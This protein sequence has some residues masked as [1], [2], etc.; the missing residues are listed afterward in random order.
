MVAFDGTNFLIAWTD[1]FPTFGSDTNGIGNL[2]ARFVNPSGGTVGQAFTIATGINIKWGK[3]R[4]YLAFYDTTYFLTYQ[5]GVDHHSEYLYMLRLGRSG[6][7]VGSAVK[8]SE[9]YA[10]EGMFA[11]DG[12]NYLLVWCKVE[13][14]LLDKDIMGQF[15]NRSGTLVGGNFLIDGGPYASDNPITLV[16]DGTRYWMGFHEQAADSSDRWNLFGRFVSTSGVVADRFMICDSSKSPFYTSAGFDGTK[17]LISWIEMA[18]APRVRGRHFNASGIP[19]DT[20]F[21]VADTVGGKFPFGGIVDFVNG[22]FIGSVTRFDSDFNDGDVYG[23]FVPS[24]VTGVVDQG[25]V[26]P[27]GFQLFQNYPNPFNPSTRIGYTLSGSGLVSLKVFD[28]L[29]REM[30]TL[31]DGE[32]EAGS[33]VV[34]FD[35]SQ[36]PSGMYFYRLETGSFAETRKMIILK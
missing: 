26:R 24:S 33:R 9:A 4:G 32:Q 28:L 5:K 21:T 20:A 12:T 8:I 31:V 22:Y 25:G 13:H 17:Y 3:G 34:E 7:P 10:R 30:A 36:L 1:S 35:A 14:P 16:F 6:N 11:F 23:L 19:L 29:G 18:G 27:G 15:V 2:Y